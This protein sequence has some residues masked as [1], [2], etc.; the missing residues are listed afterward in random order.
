MIGTT[1]SHY[2]IV[3]KLG[4][5][6]MGVVYKARDLRLDRFVCI[7]ILHPEQ[8]KD[9]SRKQRFIQEAKAAS[10]L[11]HPNIV[12]IHEIDQANGIDF[13]VMEFVAGKTLQQLTPG[14]GMPVADVL[15]Y[16]IPIAR[17]LAA[18]NAAGIVHRDVKPGNIMVGANGIVKVLDF[19]LAKL[20]APEAPADDATHTIQAHTEE[21]AIVGTAA[22]M[23]PEQAQAK[24]VD[25]RSDIFSFGAMLYEMLTGRR[26]FQG[27]NTMSTLAAILE[28]EPAPLAERDARI[29]RELERVVMR[30]LRKDPERRFQ[31]M[32]DLRVELEELKEDSDSGKLTPAQPARAS[33]GRPWLVFGLSAAL[34]LLAGAGGWLWWHSQPPRTVVHPLTRLT[35][36][37]AAVFPA[38][39]R[40]GKL[41][42]YQAAV[43]EPNPDI[44]VQQIGGGKAIR[45]THEKEGAA[46]PAF[47]PDG[48][49]IAYQRL[50][51]GIYEVP[52]LGGDARLIDSDGLGR[53]VYAAG[54][55]T[56]VFQRTAGTDTHLFTAPRIGGNPVAIQPEL[57]YAYGAVSSDGTKL[58]ALAYRKGKSEQDIKQ[59]WLI[60]ISGGKFEEVAPPSLLPGERNAPVPFAWTMPDKSAGRQWVVF[61]RR[62]GDTFNLFR[63]TI[64]DDGKVTSD[65]EQLTFT[66]LSSASSVSDNGRMVFLNAELSTNLWSLPIDTNRAQVTGDRQSLTRVEGIRDKS[67][68][69][70]H[71][72]KKVAFFSGSNLM[73]KD[74]A[75]GRETQLV[76]DVRVAGGT[77]PSI[78]PDGSFVIY[79]APNKT[80]NEYD[81]YSI[82]TAGGQPRLV[83]RSCGQPKGFS[84]DGTRLLTQ[85]GDSAGGRSKIALVE[86]ATGK[87]T[88]ALDDP[89]HTL[90]NAFY[91]W[92]DKWVVFLVQTD[93]T[94]LTFRVY[95]APVEN[96][97]PAGPD[98][99]I[100]L[101]SG[102]YHDDKP[103]LSPDGNILYFTSNRDGFICMWALRLD[104]K[105]K[106]PVSASF[107]IQH[108]HGTQR[109]YAGLSNPADIELSVS[110]DKV[111][112]NLDEFHSD[113]WMMELDPHY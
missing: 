67:P 22:Y 80:A 99:W 58:I 73:V 35:Y 61:G 63:V 38:I 36:T 93:Q 107:P 4:E 62:I 46:T 96:F 109:I 43:G 20:T 105:T 95:I 79:Y 10:S 78:S 59:W 9:E 23:S 106:H 17:A 54:G 3:E 33:R 49:E 87:V 70:S 26:A 101:T 72:G 103:Q 64:T 113:I 40:D 75:T 71:D 48:T 69:V 28:K 44:W 42:A 18:A 19:G 24:P 34:V 111:I 45:I 84:S 55:S 16:A 2:Q 108:F 15:K 21:G 81:L 51:G 65:P 39:S 25:A 85:L 88:V 47:S 52:A 27:A 32:A 53:P 8:L 112:T 76:Q 102:E 1:I 57:A 29:P 68:S 89:Q 86:L 110:K 90:W 100:Q 56:I 97:A 77:G 7:K 98:R 41:L 60:P 13:M 94:G 91:S 6:G 50:T 66:A 82:S 37:G 83:C 11:N 14:G 12:T 92:D 5:G 30:C 31:T 104:P 74:L